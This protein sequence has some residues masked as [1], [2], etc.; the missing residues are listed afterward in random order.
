MNRKSSASKKTRVHISPVRAGRLYRLL[1]HLNRK[2]VGRT[3]LLKKLR[4]GMRTFYR[5]VDLLRECGIEVDVDGDGYSLPG[6]LKDALHRLPF[7]DPEITFGD[8]EVLMKGRTQTHDKLKTLF[9]RVT[10]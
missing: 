5:D 1:K 4:I 8:V 9:K 3:D 6:T 10:K 2:P 7:P